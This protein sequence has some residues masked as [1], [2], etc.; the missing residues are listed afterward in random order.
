MAGHANLLRVPFHD[1]FLACQVLGPA[2]APWLVLCHGLGLDSQNM[3]PLA[4]RFSADWRVLLWDMPGHGDSPQILNTRIETFAEALATVVDACEVRDAVLMGF[5][6]GGTVAQYAVRNE[7]GQYRALIA[8][9]CYAPFHQPAPVSRTLIGGVIAAYRLQ[10]WAR[11]KRNF[12]Q[13]CAISDEG[14]AETM[15]AVSRSSKAVFVGMIRSLLESFRPEPD[16]DFALPL[17][18]IRGEEDRNSV[19]LGK[20]AARLRAACPHAQEVV[21]P[22]AG[23]CA[24]DDAF[25]AV[26]DALSSFLRSF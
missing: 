6:F 20:A 10:S 3:L 9:G 17:L 13:A 1:G 8:Y 25:D 16:L 11:I 2:E 19:H 12:A 5:S 4:E 21:V 15:R 7:P 26:A 23:H 22:Q 14:Q 24:H 18:L